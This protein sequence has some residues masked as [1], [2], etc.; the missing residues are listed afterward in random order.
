MEATTMTQKLNKDILPILGIVAFSGCSVNAVANLFFE[1]AQ[2]D[3]WLFWGAAVLVE[4]TTAW[5]VWSVVE[6]LRK[7]TKSNITKQD[8]KFYSII[9]T[10]FVVLAIPSLT[11]SIVANANEFGGDPL[12][13]C[14]FPL[15]SVACAVGAALPQTV[16]GYARQRQ[17]EA[18]KAQAERKVRQAERKKEQERRKM[19]SSLGKA[20]ATFEQLVANPEQS[21]ASIA[22]ALSISRQ[23]VGNHY[24]KLEQ[25]GAIRRN[26]G[27]S[28]EVLWEV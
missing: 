7:V 3:T 23:A 16:K 20:R 11:L 14:I 24:A 21:Q 18:T 9:L 28:V 8:R 6:T 5:L 19:L 2:H 25:V 4:L 26:D 12:L 17:E 13:S 27:E 22:Q 10:L 1:Q 15:L